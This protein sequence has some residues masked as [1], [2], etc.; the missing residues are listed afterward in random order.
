MESRRRIGRR[1][2]RRCHPPVFPRARTVPSVPTVAAKARV[3]GG[4]ARLPLEACSSPHGCRPRACRDSPY[5]SS[6]A[7]RCSR[8]PRPRVMR[9]GVPAPRGRAPDARKVRRRSRLGRESAVV[10]QPRLQE[11]RGHD[12]PDEATM[13]SRRATPAQR[14]QSGPFSLPLLHERGKS[15]H[16]TTAAEAAHPM[17][18]TPAQASRSTFLGSGCPRPRALRGHRDQ[19]GTVSHRSRF[20]LCAG[21]QGLLCASIPDTASRSPTRPRVCRRDTRSS[22]CVRGGTVSASCDSARAWY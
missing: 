22:M 13:A 21:T 3:A 6:G 19:S 2:R 18:A 1:G 20:R 12:D 15:R 14:Q 17:D 16:A 4:Q 5:G 10:P 8:A 9:R 11:P 7:V